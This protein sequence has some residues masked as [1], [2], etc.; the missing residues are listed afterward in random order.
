MPPIKDFFVVVVASV[1]VNVGAATVAVRGWARSRNG[2][3]GELRSILVHLITSYCSRAHLA[4]GA[5]SGI[6]CVV[7]MCVG[8]R[9]ALK[10]NLVCSPPRGSRLLLRAPPL[11]TRRALVAAGDLS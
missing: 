8:R 11:R 7:M 9:G 10:I 2:T 6:D 5:S 4:S 3:G 1:A